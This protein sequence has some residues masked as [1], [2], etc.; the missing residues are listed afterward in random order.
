MQKDSV[1]IKRY[2]LN[3]DP[4]DIKKSVYEV[5]CI[6]KI[7]LLK[8][9]KLNTYLMYRTKILL[10]KFYIKNVSFSCNCDIID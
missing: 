9:F 6:I 5:N 10:S 2:R 8:N 7:E 3:I 4:V 1:F